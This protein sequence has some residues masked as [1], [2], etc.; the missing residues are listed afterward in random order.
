M[1]LFEL[2]AELATFFIEHHFYL[3]EQW[4][5][6]LWLF[7]LGHSADI[8]SKVNK[9]NLSLQGKPLTVFVADDKI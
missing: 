8:F 4:T 6:K 1:Q 2:L 5:D 3:Q 9:V 7:R